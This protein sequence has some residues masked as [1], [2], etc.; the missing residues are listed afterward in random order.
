MRIANKRHKH[1]KITKDDTVILSS[2]VI[3]GNEKSIQSLKDNLSRPE[4]IIHYGVASVHASGHACQED[5][6]LMVK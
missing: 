1:I 2:S 4:R 6:K 3:P 5:L